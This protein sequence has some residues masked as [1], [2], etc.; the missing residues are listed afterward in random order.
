MPTLLQMHGTDVPKEVTGV[1]LLPLLAG[2]ATVRDAAIY[3][4]FGSA[5]N[6]TDGRHTLFLYP[7]EMHRTGLY[8]YTL[9]PT[10][11]KEFYSVEE[12]AEAE[13]VPPQP[14]T[15]GVPTLRVPSTPKS[16]NYKLHGPAAQN[17]TVTVLFDLATD[18]GQEH[19]I[20]DEAVQGRLCGH[21]VQLMKLNDAPPEYFERLGLAA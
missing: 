18:P 12:L 15:K 6:V 5:V 14:F 11:M 3:G 13:L 9:M 21:L 8:Q 7:P 2:D 4:V 17:D 19:P 16:P 1:S 10:H 20:T